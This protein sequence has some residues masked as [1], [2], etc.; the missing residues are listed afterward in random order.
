MITWFDA[1][2]ITLLAATTAL[3]ARRGLAGLVWGVGCVVVCFLSN[4]LFAGWPALPLAALLGFAVAWFARRL[5][6]QA[7]PWHLVA[8]AVG[9]LLLGA[10][11]VGTLA[12]SLPIDP[13]TNQYP[14]DGLP[15]AVHNAV[16]SSY[17]KSNLFGVF[18]GNNTVKTLLI[19]DFSRR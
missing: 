5:V 14:S 3:G 17:I 12:L 18:S 8:G 11:L 4:V 13:V 19:P 7:E 15:L 1:V 2:L 9:G 16:S 6:I 10:V